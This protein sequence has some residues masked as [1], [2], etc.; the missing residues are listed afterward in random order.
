MAISKP[1]EP[2]VLI[3]YILAHAKYDER[4]YLSVDILGLSFL[5][6]LDS[7]AFKT[8]LGGSGWKQLASSLQLDESVSKHCTVA[9]GEKCEV[10]GK[11]SLP[12]RLQDRVKVIEALVVPSVPHPLILGIDFWRA[13]EIIP[14]LFHGDWKFRS[15][16][17]VNTV[18]LCGIRDFDQLSEEQR[19]L[20]NSIVDDAFSKMGDRLGSTHLVEHHITTTSPPIKQRYY[21]LSPPCKK[22]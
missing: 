22:L 14:D 10:L 16:E 5:G 7:G 6:L 17:S 15:E 20:I 12:I 11:V 9:N 19:R 18:E 2:K 4:P 21:P 8:V 13:M 3:D 1:Y